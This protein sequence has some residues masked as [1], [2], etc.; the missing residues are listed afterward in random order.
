MKKAP[1]VESLPLL[2]ILFCCDTKQDIMF[3]VV[4]THLYN[5]GVYEDGGKQVY[6][7]LGCKLCSVNEEVTQVLTNWDMFVHNF[8]DNFASNG[9]VLPSDDLDD[10]SS[11]SVPGNTM[12][13][14]LTRPSGVPCHVLMEP[15]PICVD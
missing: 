13:H 5:V 11:S 7:F 12:L 2:Q 9:V 8:I 15:M 6:F 14:P 10:A 1:V 3:T 4:Q